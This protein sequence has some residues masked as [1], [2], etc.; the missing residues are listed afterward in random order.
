MYKLALLVA[1]LPLLAC[2]KVDEIKR[3]I[4]YQSF[5]KLGGTFFS[6][7]GQVTTKELH[8]DSGRLLG[9]E[10]VLEG[11]VVSYGRYDTHLVLGD[12]SGRMLVVLTDIDDAEGILEGATGDVGNSKDTRLRILGSVV[13]GK[14]G[15]PYLLARSVVVVD[16]NGSVQ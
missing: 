9:R 15:L 6:Q 14:K 11:E 2:E 4:D 7:P 8:F 10:V 16:K 13:R 3:S 1:C 12:D 5:E